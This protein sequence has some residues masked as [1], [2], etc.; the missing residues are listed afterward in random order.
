M[1][2]ENFEAVKQEE[3]PAEQSQ[4]VSVTEDNLQKPVFNQIQMTDAIKREREKAYERGKREALMV[5]EQ[6][7]QAQA[8]AEPQAAQQPSSIGGMQQLSPDQIRQM[9]AE[10][11]PQA[12][13]DHVE[14]LKNHHMV[15]SFVSKMH[16][17]ES[18]YPG[19][20]AKL[21]KL[22]YGTGT[23]APLVKMAND[24]ENTGD[25][26]HELVS[27]PMKMGNLMALMRD[28]PYLAQQA[29][30]DLSNSIKQN[31]QAKAEEAQA[32][33]PMSQIKSTS[34]GMDSGGMSIAD[35]RKMF[36]A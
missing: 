5:L 34:T 30:A 7:Q 32:R 15:E 22:D 2:D 35:F 21:N 36:K 8:P 9:I 31:M 23:L 17:A 18:R 10:Q 33:D 29:M 20:E 1:T 14:Q 13:Q 27:N 16:A 3:V 26:M 24:M 11:A 12:L 4:D 28:Q 19:L 25:V 6:Q